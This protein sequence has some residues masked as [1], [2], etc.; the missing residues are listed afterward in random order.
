[1]PNHQ[2]L[3]AILLILEQEGQS[4]ELHEEIWHQLN[5]GAN[6]LESLENNFDNRLIENINVP[7]LTDRGRKI[8]QDA[9]YLDLEREILSLVNTLAV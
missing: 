5:L 2:V 8:A 4:I 9:L 7:N 3:L 1:M 6:L